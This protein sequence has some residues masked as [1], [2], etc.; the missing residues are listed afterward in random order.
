MNLKRYVEREGP[1][2][3]DPRA[4]NY[5]TSRNWTDDP[6]VPNCNS[7]YPYYDEISCVR[8]YYPNFIFHV[9]E[10]L[11]GQCDNNTYF[12]NNRHQ[13]VQ[14]DVIYVYGSRSQLLAT[15]STSIAEYDRRLNKSIQ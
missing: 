13:C 6:Q 15:N 1:F 9:D 3:T 2:E 10:K 14:K 11:C 5:T 8:C 7:S 12:D 4:R